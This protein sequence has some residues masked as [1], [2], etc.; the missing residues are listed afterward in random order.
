MTSPLVPLASNDLLYRARV[1]RAEPFNVGPERA[2]TQP[3]FKCIR[4]LSRAMVAT[5]TTCQTW[6][7]CCFQKAARYND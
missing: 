2:T 1:G 6:L 7:V 4:Y 3:H 5:W